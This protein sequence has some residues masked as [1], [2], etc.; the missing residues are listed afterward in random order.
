MPL[1]LMAYRSAVQES[2]QSTPAQLML[3][4]NLRFPVDL[5]YSRPEETEHIMSYAR[6]LQE[7]LERVHDFARERLTLSSDQMKHYYDLDTVQKRFED[8]D[9]VCLYNPQRKRGLSP[10]LQRPWQGPYLVLKRINEVW[11]TESNWDHDPGQGWCTTTN[12]G[13]MLV[14][15]LLASGTDQAQR[16]LLCPPPMLNQQKTMRQQTPVT[17]PPAK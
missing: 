8:G 13:N 4:R 14:T 15:T 9:A 3:G 6:S 7:K 5:L 16:K 17:M 1:L 10:K 2:T 11:S 12:C